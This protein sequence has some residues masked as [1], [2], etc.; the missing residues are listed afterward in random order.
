MRGKELIGIKG[1]EGVE[2][3]SSI[4]YSIISVWGF[5]NALNFTE[6]TNYDFAYG[7]VS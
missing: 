5:S 7:K 3:P 1:W 2:G 6:I 4:R